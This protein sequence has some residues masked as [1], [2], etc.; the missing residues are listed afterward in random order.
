[1]TRSAPHTRN[2]TK[3]TIVGVGLIGGSL[4]LAIKKRFRSSV[5]VTGVDMPA[6]LR[7]ARRRG[8]IDAG[9]PNLARGVAGADL[10]LLAAPLAS[11]VKLLPALAR[12]CSPE[13]VVSDVGS[14]KL[15]VMRMAEKLFPAKNFI[16]GHPMAGVEISGIE[17]AH[18]LLFENAM[19]VLTPVRET[20]SWVP[21]RLAGFL[22]SLGARVIILDARTHDE[23]ASAVS[24][25][26][27]LTAV[28]L[29]NVVG[30]EHP[31]ARKHLRLAAGGFRDLTRIASSRFDI[32]ESILPMNAPHI[33][34]SLRLLIRELQAYAALLGPSGTG[35]LRDKFRRARELRNSIPRT[36]KGFVAPLAEVYVFVRDKPGM[37]ARMTTA[38]H[39]ASINIKDIELLKIREGTGGTFRLAFESADL[40][41]RAAVILKKR[42]FEIG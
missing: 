20:P 24:H 18:P 22:A 35:S 28:A 9:E 14:V 33:R 29:M 11:I 31:A 15:T 41:Q 25:L 7:K 38:L 42:G 2:F 4:G 36:M 34:R 26:P 1:M 6:V 17:A 10:V 37:L 3:V 27:Q 19:Y 23:V 13:T 32:W 5:T 39:R 21:A 12:H 16:G 30:R 8:A 40:A